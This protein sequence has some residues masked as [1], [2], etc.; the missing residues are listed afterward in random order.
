MA[1]VYFYYSAMNAGKTTLLLQA[2]YNYEERGLRTICFKPAIDTRE[3]AGSITSRVGLSAPC[4][5]LDSEESLY[6]ITCEMQKSTR[7]VA[8]VLI[9]EAQ[10]LTDRQA[11]EVFD[12]CDILNIPV[13]CFGLRSDF[14]GRPFSASAILLS[15]SDKLVELKAVCHCGAKATMNMRTDPQGNAV[16][17]GEQILVGGND[18]YVSVCRRHFYEQI[19]RSTS[20]Q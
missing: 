12:I 20:Q 17:S 1:K 10:F 9:D 18:T 7:P 14:L 13:L 2:R 3:E 5:M 6:R 4:T 8:C 16:T 15:K 11:E 19:S